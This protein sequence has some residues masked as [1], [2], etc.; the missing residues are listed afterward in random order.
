MI[1]DVLDRVRQAVVDAQAAG[2]PKHGR[3]TLVKRDEAEDDN[4]AEP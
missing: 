1:A 2:R 4:P 3:P